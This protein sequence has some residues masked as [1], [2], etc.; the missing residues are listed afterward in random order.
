MS[1]AGGS[2]NRMGQ[3]CMEMERSCRSEGKAPEALYYSGE[4]DLC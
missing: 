4:S 3:I 1:V 2:S